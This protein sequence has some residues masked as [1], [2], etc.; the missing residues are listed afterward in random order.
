M[1]RPRIA[2]HLLGL[3]R[4]YF[5]LYWRIRGA[6]GRVAFKPAEEARAAVFIHIPKAAGMSIQQAL[7]GTR[8][9]HGHVP[10]I[11]YAA[12]DRAKFARSF[13]FSVMRDPTE[14]FISA[15]YFLKS[16][17]LTGRD[18]AWAEAVLRPFESPEA[19][20]CAMEHDAMLRAQIRSWVHF[21]PQS[22]YLTDRRGALIVDY[23]GQMERFD[24]SLG[25]IAQRLGLP[26][27]P[28]HANRSERPAQPELSLT[29]RR[30][31]CR[32]Y[33]EDFAL[34]RKSGGAA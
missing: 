31:L 19:L 15:F 16:G 33:G 22:W 24:T 26:Y 4:W 3:G 21:T 6:R 32:L 20:L 7:F 29:A 9:L 30:V 10:A 8:A 13:S 2:A 23:I 1:M 18:R 34:Y 11:A 27:T 5:H 12:R 28:V 17:G 25:A 14:R